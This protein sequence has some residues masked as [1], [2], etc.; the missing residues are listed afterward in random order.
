MGVRAYGC[1]LVAEFLFIHPYWNGSDPTVSA[2]APASPEPPF[3]SQQRTFS[4]GPIADN[5]ISGM[6]AYVGS[7][8][9]LD[10]AGARYRRC[11]DR[12]TLNQRAP[13][14]CW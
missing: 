4:Q 11:M 5:A 14:T 8:M 7:Q 3:R 12:Y 6:K 10:G 1:I 13:I 2:V 9:A